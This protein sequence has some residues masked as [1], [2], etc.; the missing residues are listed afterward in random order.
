M[1]THTRLGE[2]EYASFGQGPAVLVS[3]GTGGGYDRGLF[4]ANSL[5]SDSFR[6]IAVSRP[7][8]LRTP[9]SVGKTAEEQ[10]DALAALLDSIGVSSAALIGVSGGAPAVLQFALRHADR[11]RALVLVSAVTQSLPRWRPSVGD[12]LARRLTGNHTVVAASRRLLQT[13]PPAPTGGISR[14]PLAQFL[15][16]VASYSS[17]MAGRDNDYQQLA[18]LPEYPLER[19]ACP[20]LM[21]HGTTDDEVPFTHA[22]SA[23]RQIPQAELLP[24]PGAGHGLLFHTP[25][26]ITTRMVDFLEKHARAT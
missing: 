15:N 24:V 1:V 14:N 18:S 23:A 20:V 3:H 10:A 2:I 4:V 12:R 16:K 19:I 9:L 8:Y 7:G 11:C 26:R 5:G 22:Q 6:F 17:R 25:E 21:V 13:M